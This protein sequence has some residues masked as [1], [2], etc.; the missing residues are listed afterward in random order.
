MPRAVKTPPP[1][2]AAAAGTAVTGI[3][4]ETTSTTGTAD[5][6]TPPATP[7]RTAAVPA[8]ATAVAPKDV[9]PL[10]NLPAPSSSLPGLCQTTRWGCLVQTYP[11]SLAPKSL[12]LIHS[13]TTC[14]CQGREEVIIKDY[15]LRWVSYRIDELKEHP[16]KATTWARASCEYLGI[17]GALDET[18]GRIERLFVGEYGF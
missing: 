9:T 15:I 8:T 10:Q 16:V 3:K 11:T 5:T 17:P 1:T 14:R 12:T 18:L 7:T 4:K 2:P 6:P 13:P